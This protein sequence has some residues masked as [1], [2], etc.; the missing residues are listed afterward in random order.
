MTPPAPSKRHSNFDRLQQRAQERA[1]RIY[2]SAE[3]DRDTGSRLRSA[4]LLP[5]ATEAPPWWDQ[6]PGHC[7]GPSMQPVDWDWAQGRYS[8]R[9][10]VHVLRL[11]FKRGGSRHD[12]LTCQLQKH[13]KCH[14]SMDWAG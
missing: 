14:T 1:L 12:R 8:E 11:G 2:A 6:L 7:V 10:W 13:K 5:P 9:A 4:S 3:P